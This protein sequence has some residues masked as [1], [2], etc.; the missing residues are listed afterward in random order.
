MI[1]WTCVVYECVCVCAWADYKKG[2]AQATGSGC[3]SEHTDVITVLLLWLAEV[4]P[5]RMNLY[6]LASGDAFRF[7]IE[8]KQMAET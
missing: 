2:V 5:A 8:L 1:R 4:Q 6:L 7:I 3:A